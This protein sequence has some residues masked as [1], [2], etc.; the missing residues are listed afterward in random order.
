MFSIFGKI[1][2]PVENNTYFEAGT[3]GE[4]LF[5][6]LANIIKFTGV[7]AGIFFVVQ[8][9]FAGYAFLSASGDPKKAESAF[10]KIWQ[11]LIGLVI[12]A[13]SFVIAAFVGKILGIDILNPE[14]VGPEGRG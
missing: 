5:L 13:A 2:A 11:S 7:I 14:I 8:I 3:K 4:G 12:V 9:I 1:E 10:N 6:L